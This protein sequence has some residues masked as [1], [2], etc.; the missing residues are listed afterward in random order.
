M[1]L[2][3]IGSTQ[4]SARIPGR[5]SSMRSTPSLLCLLACLAGCGSTNAGAERLASSRPTS[6]GASA[7]A[8]NAGATGSDLGDRDIIKDPTLAAALRLYDSGDSIGAALAFHG[9]LS[10]TKDEADRAA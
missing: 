9:A 3:A 5:R 1:I 10:A 2:L 7:T 6:G 4:A 8:T